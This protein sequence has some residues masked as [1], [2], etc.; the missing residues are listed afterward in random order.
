MKNIEIMVTDD[1]LNRIAEELAS[2]MGIPLSAES[3][4][5]VGTPVLSEWD[6][7]GALDRSSFFDGVENSL[8]TFNPTEVLEAV[9]LGSVSVTLESALGLLGSDIAYW[10]YEVDVGCVLGIKRS[11]NEFEILA[12]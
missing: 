4:S 12:A 7:T 9:S 8:D 11:D 10:D 6:T 2:E 3:D 5:Y 1:E